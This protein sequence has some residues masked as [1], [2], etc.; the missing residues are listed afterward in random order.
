MVNSSIIIIKLSDSII[1]ISIAYQ[2]FMKLKNVFINVAFMG[3]PSFKP[4]KVSFI[5]KNT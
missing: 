1:I 4:S 5:I 3:Y 2:D